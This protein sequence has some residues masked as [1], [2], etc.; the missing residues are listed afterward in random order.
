M[1]RN[2]YRALL[3]PYKPRLGWVRYL[4]NAQPSHVPSHLKQIRTLRTQI[5]PLTFGESQRQQN[6]MM[7]NSKFQSSG[8]DGLRH[9]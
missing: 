5:Q 4:A 3:T 2:E 7:A 9:G 6:T 8:Q 1:Y